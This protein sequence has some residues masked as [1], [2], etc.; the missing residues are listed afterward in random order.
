MGCASRPEAADPAGTEAVVTA[1][2]TAAAP[3]RVAGRASVTR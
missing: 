2:H 3:G 1:A